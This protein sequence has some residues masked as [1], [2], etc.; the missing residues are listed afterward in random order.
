MTEQ[1]KSTLRD[2]R[3]SPALKQTAV[4]IAAGDSSADLRTLG[5]HL[6]SADFLNRL[7]SPKDYQGSYTGLRLA[8]V[9][10]TLMDNRR[11]AVDQ[12]LLAL[13]AARD[14][15]A[16]VL[17]MQLL[18]HALAVVRPSP[19]DAIAYWELRS[20]PGSSLAY[21]VAEALCVNQSQPAMALLEREF[22][23]PKHHPDLKVAWM[24]Q[25]ILPR[26][27]DEPLLA[28]CEVVLNRSLPVELRPSLVE[29][30]FDYRPNEWYRD[31]APPQPPLRALASRSA[32]TLLRR[33]ADY[34][35]ANLTLSPQ[36][37]VVVEAVRRE[38]GEQ[39]RPA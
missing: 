15:Q 38:L 27:N 25:L 24:R 17:R 31:C 7:D 20:R 4:R 11:P 18:V 39:T 28:C 37:K 8:R 5:E 36:L 3:E 21:D 13:I 23:E 2:S 16:H 22:A 9:L 14:Y 6:I 35:L 1:D 29:A 19:P 12:V 33:L 32:K 34:S 10:K 26:R 30:L